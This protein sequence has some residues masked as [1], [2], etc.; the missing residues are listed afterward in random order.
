[1]KL[2]FSFSVI[3]IFLRSKASEAVSFSGLLNKAIPFDMIASV[4]EIEFERVSS[5]TEFSLSIFQS[6]FSRSPLT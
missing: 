6:G 3:M 2:R 5:V 1:M 4:L